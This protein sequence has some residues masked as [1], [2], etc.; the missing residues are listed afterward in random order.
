MRRIRRPSPSMVVALAALLVAVGGTAYAT[1][2]GKPL[3]GGARNP[4]SDRSKAL[5]KETQII[6]NLS[7]YG[8]RQSNKSS[9]GGGAIYGCRSTT[10]GT[11]AG[12]E[13]CIR[14]NNLSSGYAF[15]LV[16][17]GNQTG[18]IE[19]KDASGVPFTTNATGVATGLNADQVDGKH[20]A[21]FLGKTE[22]AASSSA[23][24]N[25][26]VVPL[27]RFT[28]T[29]SGTL[30]DAR[31]AA[32]EIPIAQKGQLTLYAK[33]FSN[34]AGGIVNGEVYARTSADQS[35]LETDDADDLTGDGEPFLNTG[36]AEDAR[37]VA[38]IS[39][40]SVAPQTD[41]DQ[42][43]S[44]VAFS[45]DGSSMTGNVDLAARQ[46]AFGGTGAWGTGDAC[47]FSATV[48]TGP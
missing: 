14:A 34:G 41:I 26:T 4:G 46:T 18:R 48:V 7:G 35:V 31:N 5:T 39:A 37:R 40:E 44:F 24:S 27:K 22:T 2:E 23:L 16:T 36:T 13:P 3:I 1:G 38:A 30:A 43:N 25:F 12:N 6:A 20:A 33:C 29:A 21:D 28:A 45:P 42:E 17:S 15:E 47:W 8:T 9:N 10:G 32:P 11:P 19:T